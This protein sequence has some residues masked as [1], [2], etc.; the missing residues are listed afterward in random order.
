MKVEN[1]KHPSYFRQLWRLLAIFG[2][3]KIFFFFYHF[4]Q[5]KEFVTEY[6]FSI[7]FFFWR[8]G[9][10]SPLKKS[11]GRRAPLEERAAKILNYGAGKY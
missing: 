2:D 4:F 6:S 10:N 3:F 1:L 9:E 7:F 5:N 8:N 11:P